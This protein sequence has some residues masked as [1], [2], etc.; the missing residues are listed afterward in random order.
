[1]K[2]AR[3]ESKINDLDFN[4]WVN[5][6]YNERSK[7][8]LVIHAV[9]KEPIKEGDIIKILIIPAKDLNTEYRYTIKK[10][11]IARNYKP[12]FCLINEKLTQKTIAQL[13]TALNV[14]EFAQKGLTT[15]D[16]IIYI[17]HLYFLFANNISTN[18]SILENF[19]SGKG[20]EFNL[21]KIEDK[22]R[23]EELAD[24]AHQ[25][26]EKVLNFWNNHLANY[27][28]GFIQ[29]K[30]RRIFNIS[31]NTPNAIIPVRIARIFV[32]KFNFLAKSLLFL[33]KSVSSLV[34]ICIF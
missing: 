1:M 5:E 30:D 33:L 24:I 18:K 7:F 4:K 25:K 23:Y 8:P 19:L 28:D 22:E 29:I 34:S 6:W 10:E 17:A 32:H 11:K 3:Q 14:I 26:L 2:M 12:V 9:F 15:C 27:A 20:R 13:K 31:Y 16:K 21:N